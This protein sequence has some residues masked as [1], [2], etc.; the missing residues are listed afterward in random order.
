MAI[1]QYIHPKITELTFGFPEFVPAWKKMTLFH[2]FIFLFLWLATPIFHHAK[3]K[4][5]QSPFNLCET[6]TACKKSVSSISSSRN[7]VSHS[8]FDHAPPKTF[9]STFNFCKFIS[10]YKKWGCFI[11]LLWRNVW[12]KNLATWTAESIPA[13]I[14]EL[15]NP[16]FGLFLVHFPNFKVQKNFPKKSATNKLIRF[17]STMPKFRET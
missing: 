15:K 7:Q 1:F 5:F 8:L 11:D 17:F 14:S 12:F 3:P 6:V 16:L 9:Q 13:Y 10:T 4:N 2:L